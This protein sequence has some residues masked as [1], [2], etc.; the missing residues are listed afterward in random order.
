MRVR[1]RY[2]DGVD[3]MAGYYMGITGGG[4]GIGCSLPVT[5]MAAS[6]KKTC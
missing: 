1:L 4:G 6:L 2:V 3:V 5:A